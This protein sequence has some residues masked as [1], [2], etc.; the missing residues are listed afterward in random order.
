[1]A[2]FSSKEEALAHLQR[3]YLK[4]GSGLFFAGINKLHR[5]YKPLLKQKDIESFLSSQ[6][7]YTRLKE[8]HRPFK[9]N[10][11]FCHD[12]RMLM[13]ID[14]IQLN[15]DVAKIN[16][17]KMY[18][19]MAIDVFSRKVWAKML[20][21]KS[22]LDVVPTFENMLTEEIALGAKMPDK[23]LADRGMEFRNSAFKSL[24]V[25]YGIHLFHNF[26]SYHAA[27]VERVN[28][29]IQRKLMGLARAQGSYDFHDQLEAVVASYNNAYHRSLNM[30]PN[31]ADKPS[32]RYL[33]RLMNA[34]KYSKFWKKKKPKFQLNEICRI[35]FDKTKFSR[36]YNP[37]FSDTLYRVTGINHKLPIVMY[38][39]ARVGD[40][41]PLL[42]KFYASELCK[43]SS[44]D[45]YPI[46]K[47]V[48]VNKKDK[49]CLVRWAGYDAKFD[50]IVPLSE[51]KSY[52]ELLSNALGET[53]TDNQEHAENGK[54]DDDNDEK[55]SKEDKEN[56]EQDHHWQQQEEQQQQQAEREEN[57]QSLS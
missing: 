19:F 22:A 33:V 4:P 6:Y 41:E 29:T 20:A 26:S 24:M 31:D 52:K 42:G 27:H 49:T 35:S 57:E 3:E 44:V 23:I 48:K 36:S 34:K 7:S 46:E 45:Y 28:K 39:L 17:N 14:L 13:E 32:N 16:K 53:T 18:I 1:M 55:A 51:V 50:S 8:A 43:V 10:P 40:D 47:I 37:T 2:Q 25:K 38:S 30:S 21:T 9:R 12:R 5:Y 11:V 15:P 56:V 54:S